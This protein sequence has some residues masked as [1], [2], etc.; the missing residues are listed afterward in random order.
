MEYE[1]KLVHNMQTAAQNAIVSIVKKVEDNV[2]CII[3]VPVFMPPSATLKTPVANP[4]G[5]LL[6]GPNTLVIK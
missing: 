2:L 5:T 1:E 6:R 4:P 3:T